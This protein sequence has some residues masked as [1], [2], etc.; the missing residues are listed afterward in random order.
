MATTRYET[1]AQIVKD[2][3][4]SVGLEELSDPFSSTDPAQVRLCRLLTVAG[5]EIV[6]MHDWPQLR[7]ACDITAALGDGRA[8]T[9][10]AD[11]VSIVPDTAWNQTQDQRILGPLTAEEWNEYEANGNVWGSMSYRIV[12]DTFAIVPPADT[13]DGDAIQYEYQ[14]KAWVMP[15]GETVPT[16]DRADTATDTVWLD[17]ALVFAALTY[18]WLRSNGQETVGAEAAYTRALERAKGMGG[19]APVLPLKPI[20]NVNMA[21]SSK[22]GSW[23]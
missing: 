7:K 8:Y 3:A 17:P 23:T 10:P 6:Q 12:Q 20:R 4:V 5:R 9:L 16:E 21:P 11:Y 19:G 14:S 1:A 2:V 13:T 18:H 15:T 22:W